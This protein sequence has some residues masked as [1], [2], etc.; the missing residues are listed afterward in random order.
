[1]LACVR[2]YVVS[3][4]GGDNYGYSLSFT[5]FSCAGLV[6]D[7][8]ACKFASEPVTRPGVPADPCE[9]AVSMLLPVV[10]CAYVSVP[11]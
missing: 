11:I 9:H 6:G 8:C 10:P 2:V 3:S 4:P 1:M 5:L 7:L